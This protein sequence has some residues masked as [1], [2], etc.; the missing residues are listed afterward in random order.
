MKE[1]ERLKIHK[2]TLP[3][4]LY[5]EKRDGE[6]VEKE[7]DCC[8]LNILGVDCSRRGPMGKICMYNVSGVL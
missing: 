2:Q 4:V 7:R 3:D 5:Y 1:R 6:P 8:L